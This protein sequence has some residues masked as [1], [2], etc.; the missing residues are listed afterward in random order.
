M[1]DP[2]AL[3]FPVALYVAFIFWLS[4]APRVLPGARLIPR[5]DKLYHFL[6]YAPLGWMLARALRGSSPRLGW[7]VVAWAAAAL[8]ACVAGSDEFYQSFIDT[9]IASAWD[10]LA[11]LAGSV[12]GCSYFVSKSAR[13]P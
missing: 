4:S 8:A 7:T 13:T 3:W 12:L 11:D 2:F 1:P 5:I 10:A 6:E 9:R